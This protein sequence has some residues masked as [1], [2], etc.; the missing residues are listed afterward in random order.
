MKYLNYIALMSSPFIYMLWSGFRLPE[1]GAGSEL[2]KKQVT[3][4]R[5]ISSST[6]YLTLAIRSISRACRNCHRDT[7]IVYLV[8]KIA[9][10]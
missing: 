6:V 9:V 3:L 5:T 2:A 1:F 8:T 7:T 4:P 10:T